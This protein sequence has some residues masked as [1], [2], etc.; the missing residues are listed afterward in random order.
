MR[1]FSGKALDG[2]NAAGTSAASSLRSR[3]LSTKT[4]VSCSPTARETNAATTLESTP[5]ERPSSTPSSPTCSRMR[6]TARSMMLATVQSPAQPA[7]SRTN[8]RSSSP[9]RSVCM[10]S[11]WNCTPKKRR[12]A[13]VMAAIGAL[14]LAAA[15][16]KPGGS[17]VTLSPW[18]IHTSR[19]L[20]KPLN[21]APSPRTCSSAWPNSL[22]AERSTAPPSC[23]A[24]ACIP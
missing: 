15:I 21:S 10:T 4:Q 22:C 9:P 23:M 19:V 7:M 8:R 18:L 2:P 13:C 5:P 1:S 17:A 3:P 6:A 24:M 11:G 12:S 14:A 20:P 16:S